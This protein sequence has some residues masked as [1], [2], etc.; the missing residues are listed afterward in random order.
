M[1][2]EMIKDGDNEELD[3]GRSWLRL[4]RVKIPNEDGCVTA[5][6]STAETAMVGSGRAP[7]SQGEIPPSEELTCFTSGHSN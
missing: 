5:A 2:W 7:H 1:C 6:A 4:K 3:F